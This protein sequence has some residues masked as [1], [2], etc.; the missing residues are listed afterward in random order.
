M[1]S[2]SAARGGASLSLVVV[3]PEADAVYRLHLAVG[4]NGFVVTAHLLERDAEVVQ[5]RTHSWMGR[6]DGRRGAPFCS[7]DNEEAVSTG[8]LS[9]RRQKRD[10][11]ACYD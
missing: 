3:R 11:R 1:A 5:G 9:S 10:L 6:R 7:G 4:F 2:A 8:D